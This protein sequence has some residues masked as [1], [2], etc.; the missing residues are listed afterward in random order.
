MTERGRGLAALFLLWMLLVAGAA[1]APRI[2]LVTMEP[3]EEYWSRFGHNAIL[4]D[5]GDGNE[6]TLYNYGYFDFDEPGFLLRFLK[7]DMRYRL[8]ALPFSQD[9]AYYAR[10][11]RGV[12]LQWLAIEDAAARDLADFLAWNARPENAVYRYDYFTANCSTKVRDALDDALGGLLQTQLSGR[13]R[14]LTYR[15]ESLRLGMPLP[16]MGFGMHIGLGPY[17]DRPL[18][19]WEESFVPMRLR[20]A[21]REVRLPDGRPLVTGEDTLLVHRLPPAWDEPP[22]W[23]ARYALLG[24]TLAIGLLWLGRRTPR[25]LAGIAAG[26]WALC[27]VTG[28]GL[29]ALWLLTDHVAAWGNENLLLFNPLCLAL[30]PGARALWR[31]REPARSFHRLL[32]LVLLGAGLALFLRFLPFRLQDN[33]DWIALML[34]LHAALAWALRRRG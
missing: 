1:A 4:V 26:L 16:W 21:V 10:A 24:L 27:G 15:M 34:P 32:M 5:E 28:L 30:L 8:V 19:R 2:G 11:G 14:G 22:Q 18:S 33:A 31:G 20:E 3:G 7:G 17:A 23:R 13:S 25:A 9:L 6:P 12:T 29:L